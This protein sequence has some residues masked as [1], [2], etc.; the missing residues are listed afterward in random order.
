MIGL[1]G[2]TMKTFVEPEMMV[3]Q[4][5]IDDVVTTSTGGLENP[6]GGLGWG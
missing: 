5:G 2:E 1:G 6:E 3:L 4:F